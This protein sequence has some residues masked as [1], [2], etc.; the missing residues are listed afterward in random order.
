MS[1]GGPEQGSAEGGPRDPVVKR[2]EPSKGDL[3]ELSSGG[4]GGGEPG[5]G[6]LGAG[7][8][9]FKG[10]GEVTSAQSLRVS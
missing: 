2:G 1:A 9:T 3:K 10:P 5:V 8:D 6:D 7:G 4:G